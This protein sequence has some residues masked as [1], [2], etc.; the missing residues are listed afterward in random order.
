VDCFIPPFCAGKGRLIP[1][2]QTLVTSA[3]YRN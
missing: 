3:E 2:F 1:S